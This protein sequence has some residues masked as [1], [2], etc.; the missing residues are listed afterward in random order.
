MEEANSLTKYVSRVYIIHRRDAFRASKI[1]QARTL[2]PQ[3]PGRLGLRGRRGLRRLGR[4]PLGGRQGEE[5]GQRRGVR[6]PGGR[7]LLGG[8]LELDSEGYVDTKLGSTHTSGGLRCRGRSGQEVP[9]G[10]Y[11]RWIRYVLSYIDPLPS[12]F[13][14]Q[15]QA[16]IMCRLP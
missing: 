12:G 11:C 2:Q 3:N 4:W 9:P 7:A 16:F 6:H 1:M 5:P 8:Q 14:D 13:V 15:D 10:H